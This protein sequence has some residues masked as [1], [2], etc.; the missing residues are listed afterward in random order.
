[1]T[2]W[3]LAASQGQGPTEISTAA[4]VLEV[5]ADNAAMAPMIMRCS[6]PTGVSSLI[7]RF[8]ARSKTSE[9]ESARRRPFAASRD[10]GGDGV[11]FTGGPQRA[12]RQRGRKQHK[13]RGHITPDTAGD[14]VVD[15]RA[16]HGKA[17]QSGRVDPQRAR[18]DQRCWRQETGGCASSTMRVVREHESG[19]VGKTNRV[20]CLPWYEFNKKFPLLAFYQ[21]IRS[22]KRMSNTVRGILPRLDRGPFPTSEKSHGS[23]HAELNQEYDAK[24]DNTGA[25]KE[26]QGGDEGRVVVVECGWFDARYGQLGPAKLG[27]DPLFAGIQPAARIDGCLLKHV[28]PHLDGAGPPVVDSKRWGGGGRRTTSVGDTTSATQRQGWGRKRQ[29][30]AWRRRGW[31]VVE[32]FEVGQFYLTTPLV[33]TTRVATE[34]KSIQQPSLSI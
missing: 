16:R 8:I 18:E 20:T 30:E 13:Q 3:G 34:N 21:S 6:G 22:S 2:A 23:I 29:M 5:E 14:Y 12:L 10:A 17:S 33:K 15:P 24:H 28:E 25:N 1:M 27:S 7:E 32:C 4:M 11:V 9:P 26:H 31:E 19:R